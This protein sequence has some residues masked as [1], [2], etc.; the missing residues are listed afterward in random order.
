MRWNWDVE[1]YRLQKEK[2]VCRGQV[3]GKERIRG[4]G[5]VGISG[6]STKSMICGP[7][8][9]HCQGSVASHIREKQEQL[10][11]HSLMGAHYN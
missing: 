4:S 2:G 8:M 1:K 11:I 10:D 6:L 7:S 3:V 5:L 9:N